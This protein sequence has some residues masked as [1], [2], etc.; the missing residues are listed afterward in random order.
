M[1]VPT[2]YPRNTFQYLATLRTVRIVSGT[3]RELPLEEGP[4]SAFLAT[5]DAPTASEAAPALRVDAVYTGLAGKWLVT[6]PGNILDAPTLAGLFGATPPV[7]I[8][9]Q[10][11]NIRVVQ[12]CA[13]APSRHVVAP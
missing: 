7:L 6:F 1:P 8:I 5:S 13:Y 9:E 3:A 12:P 2:I 11:N 4:V 10:P